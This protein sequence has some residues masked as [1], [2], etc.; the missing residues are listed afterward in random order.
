MRRSINNGAELEALGGLCEGGCGGSKLKGHCPSRNL[1]NQLL[2]A[3]E[4]DEPGPGSLETHLIDG[5]K[6]GSTPGRRAM[7]HWR[8]I[9]VQ[10]SRLRRIMMC[11]CVLYLG[12]I[13]KGS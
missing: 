3:L 13:C 2:D 11:E 10:L 12:H 8:G 4:P 7:V 9:E 6:H 5:W 1:I